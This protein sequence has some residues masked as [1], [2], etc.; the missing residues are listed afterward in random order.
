[1]QQHLYLMIH[2]NKLLAKILNKIILLNNFKP[3]LFYKT[4]T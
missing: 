3:D 1:M 2:W 4:L